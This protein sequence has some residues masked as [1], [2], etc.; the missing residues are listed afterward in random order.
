VKVLI[1]GGGV[2]GLTLAYHL[3]RERHDVVILEA[4]TCGHATSNKAAGMITPASEVHLGE[5][6]LLRT[7][8]RARD[9][10]A[11]FVDGLTLGQPE[12]I[13]FH[14]NGSLLCAL[15]ADGAHEL[16]RLI[17]FQKSCGLDVSEL[18]ATQLLELE[19]NLTHRVVLSALAANEAHVDTLK[20]LDV[21][22]SRV[23][24]LGVAVHEKTRVTELI[25]S[26]DKISGVRINGGAVVNADA[27]VMA[28]GMSQ[29]IKGLPQK[30]LLPLRPVKGQALA[31][32]GPSGLLKRPLRVYHRYPI[33]LVP[34]STGEIVVGA[35]CEEL[36]D[37][38]VTAG[39]LMDLIYSAWRVL[40]QIY[41]YPVQRTWAGLRPATPDNKPI[42]GRIGTS[43]L[44]TLLG[45]YRHGIMAS[46]YL[47]GELAKLISDKAT[48]LAWEEFSPHRFEALP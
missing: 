1:I 14:Q 33:Y 11:A 3:K 46:P 44:F 35:T 8:A 6:A 4:G 42:L 45:L 10:Y 23:S 30:N 7:F 41:D 28:T 26:G 36:S 25:H 19:P 29:L 32:S 12:R 31:V 38:S 9:T 5:E 16:S 48:E 2:A 24:E 21:L 34:R 17:G 43:N 27:V 20:F 37:E 47:A 22:H 13:D 39:G 18:T 40:P 15:D